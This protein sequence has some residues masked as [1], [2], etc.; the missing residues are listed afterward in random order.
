MGK[1]WHALS[2]AAI[3]ATV[4]HLGIPALDILAALALGGW[5]RE[6]RQHD[7]RLTRHQWLEALAWP[8]G[9]VA[10]YGIGLLLL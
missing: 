7:W 5:L 10:V 9:G 2:G 6:V 4:L 8:A 1:L 3:Y